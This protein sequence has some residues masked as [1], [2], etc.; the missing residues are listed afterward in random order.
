[1]PEVGITFPAGAWPVGETRTLKI[2]VLELKSSA[3]SLQNVGSTR[4]A[5][6]AVYFSPSG[7]VFSKPVELKIAFSRFSD[8]GTD[9]LVVHRYDEASNT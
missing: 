2:S 9:T 1:M 3:K 7:I 5:G 4:L 8:F 6:K